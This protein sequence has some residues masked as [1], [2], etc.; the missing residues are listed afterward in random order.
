MVSKKIY[1]SEQIIEQTQNQV[2][3]Y[4]IGI[5]V[6][7]V[8]VIIMFADVLFNANPRILSHLRGDLM[9]EFLDWRYFGFNQLKQGNL[10]LW[11]PHVFC[12]V[13]FFGGFQSALLYPPNFLF[14]VL[15]LALAVNVNIVLHILLAGLFMFLWAWH[16]GLKPQ[17]C[18]FSAVLLMF[19]GPYFMHIYPGHLSNLCAMAWVPLIFLSIDGICDKRSLNWALLGVAAIS[20]LI[21]AGHPQYVFY[22]AVAS[23]IYCALSL[24]NQPQRARVLSLLTLMCIWAGLLVSVQLLTGLEESAYTVRGHGGV[25]LEFAASG[26]FPLANLMTLISPDFL[27]SLPDDS[28]WGQY[29]MWEMSLFFSVTGLVLAVYGQVYGSARQRHFCMTLVI[30][31]F[32]LAIGVHTPLFRLL[33]RIVPGFNKFRG[34]SKF[35]FQ[36]IVFAVMLAGI[37]LHRLIN[38]KPSWR[39]IIGI[40]SV[41]IILTVTAGI[42][43]GS[44]SESGIDG[45]WHDFMKL[46][47]SA[48]DKFKESYIDIALYDDSSFV[49]SAVHRASNSLLAAAGSLLL[50]AGFFALKRRWNYAVYAIILLALAELAVF[51]LPL[52]PTFDL[53]DKELPQPFKEEISRLPGDFRIINMFDRN[54]A[55][56]AGLFDIWGYDPGV[57]RRYSEFMAFSQGLDPGSATQDVTF[58][59]TNRL[60]SLL[61]LRYIIQPKDQEDSQPQRIVL[62]EPIP[63]RLMLVRNFQVAKDRDSILR[64][65]AS[66][67]FDLNRTVVLESPPQPLPQPSN[68]QGTV[69]IVDESTDYLTIEADIDSPAILLVTDAYHPNW[70][71]EPLSGS[72]QK[73][74]QVMPAD[75]VLRA[76]SLQAGRHI[77]RMEYRPKA[78]TI[79][80]WI[81]IV[82][83]AAYLVLCLQRLYS[84]V[85]RQNNSNLSNSIA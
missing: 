25:G 58:S 33:Y 45:W 39:W 57:S 83:L 81:S 21:L 14:M 19:C 11:N 28:Y 12:G 8:L 56:M 62:T 32:I 9:T 59:R 52:R 3:G 17:A 22:T 74:Y 68:N 73:N 18:F 26:S 63:P 1:Q 48:A 49:R 71:A 10:A 29:P 77:F 79:G 15:P 85:R 78:F 54:G 53:T 38:N 30:I 43:A 7:V 72:C 64:L 47:K 60:F 2:W 35:T 84:L 42:I 5:C 67:G 80:M 82:S 55:T 76:V 27:G 31:L 40:A 70:R 24:L 69:K 16:R 51:A 34:S 75:Y 20:M 23:A 37:G 44:V 41:A 46:V 13:P 66:P 61:R 36:M 6:F 50:L 4:L 65:L